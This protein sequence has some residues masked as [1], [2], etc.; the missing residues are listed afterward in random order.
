MSSPI[1][2]RGPQG[3]PIE[4]YALANLKKGRFTSRE[5]VVWFRLLSEGGQATAHHH[6]TR[7]P[8]RTG[9]GREEGEGMKRRWPYC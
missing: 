7:P 8:D 9:R 2:S 5:R 1:R 6:R 4:A 3:L